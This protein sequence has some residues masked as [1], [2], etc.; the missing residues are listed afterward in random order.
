[1]L[2]ETHPDNAVGIANYKA[3]K[4][5]GQD[6]LTSS[7]EFKNC[8]TPT[9]NYGDSS[10]NLAGCKHFLKAQN[11]IG[12]NS[13][14]LASGVETFMTLDWQDEQ[15]SFKWSIFNTE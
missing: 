4:D 2:E 3:K 14:A 5:V 6:R 1:M 12:A 7:Y 10:S 9:L 15:Y 11:S 13:P 8:M